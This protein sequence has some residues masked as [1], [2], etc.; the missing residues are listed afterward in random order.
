MVSQRIYQS[1]VGKERSKALH[2]DH[3]LE[4]RSLILSFSTSVSFL[5]LD[6]LGIAVIPHLTV[7]LSVELDF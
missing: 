4:D 7:K 5:Q 3:S 1:E 6:A 2:P